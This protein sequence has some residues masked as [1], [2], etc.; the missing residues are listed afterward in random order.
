[1]DRQLQ[2][3]TTIDNNNRQQQTANAFIETA[4]G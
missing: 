1:M 2:Q 3:T 4:N